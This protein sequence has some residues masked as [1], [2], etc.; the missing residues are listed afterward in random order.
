MNMIPQ[1]SVI[2]PN[3]NGE[4]YI[5]R[6]LDSVL[7]QNIEDIEI[8][9]VD[10]GSTDKSREYLSE[11]ETF[12][13]VNVINKKNE[14]VSSARNIGIEKSKGKYICFLDSDD[15][16]EPGMLKTVLEKIE[17]NDV[18]IY[19]YSNYMPNG[20]IIPRNQKEIHT[21]GNEIQANLFYYVSRTHFYSPVNKLF[22]GNILR[23]NNVRFPI[24]VK[25]GEDYIFNLSWISY[26][27]KV[28]FIND[29]LYQYYKFENTSSSCMDLD[30]WKEQALMVKE[31]FAI[32]TENTV[33]IAEFVIKRLYSVYVYYAHRVKMKETVRY[34]RLYWK[35]CYGKKGAFVNKGK[36]IYRYLITLANRDFFY[37][38]YMALNLIERAIKLRY[39]FKN[40]KS[41]SAKCS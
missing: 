9:V 25:T 23:D 34:L 14:G 5:S 30:R 17:D 29:H 11:Y 18:L 37:M 39:I 3:Y 13:C 2:I 28:K 7:T 33:Y 15:C 32:Y 40:Y 26:V 6:C 4:K 22:R 10:D 38:L 1:V 36:K 27:D 41:K 31:T 20:H 16:L 19:S 35:E 24:G 8:I 21:T 12:K